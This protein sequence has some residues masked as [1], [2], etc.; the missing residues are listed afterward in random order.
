MELYEHGI[1]TS[2]DTDGI[3]LRFGNDDA[4]IEMIHHIC[5]RDTWLGN[6]LAEGGHQGIREDRQRTRSST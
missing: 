6:V 5:K 4:V 3:D 2:K 1:L